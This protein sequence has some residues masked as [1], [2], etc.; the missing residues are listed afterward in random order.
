MSGWA[1]IR[2]RP[3]GTDLIHL[4]HATRQVSGAPGASYLCCH[5]SSFLTL[6][7]QLLPLTAASALP[8]G[9]ALHTDLELTSLT[10]LPHAPYDLVPGACAATGRTPLTLLLQLLLHACCLLPLL[11]LPCFQ[12][13]Q[14]SFH[15][16]THHPPP[17]GC[18]GG[19]LYTCSPGCVH[20]ARCCCPSGPR[21]RPA[22]SANSR[23][24]TASSAS[25]SGLGDA[26]VW[27]P[28]HLALNASRR[29]PTPRRTHANADL[30]PGSRRAV[31]QQPI[32]HAGRPPASREASG[33][34]GRGRSAW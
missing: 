20:A 11:R 16:T 8:R 23:T 15:H 22:A 14:L 28:P 30:G 10:Q 5:R 34:G 24:R 29:Q 18:Q 7:L 21:P 33:G 9:I 4:V 1:P 25:R 31:P 27:A 32:A 6:P 17:E 3:A 2:P 19:L 26:E 13:L 12:T